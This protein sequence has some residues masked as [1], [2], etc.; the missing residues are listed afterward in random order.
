MA[1]G[2]GAKRQQRSGHSRHRQ[3]R[4]PAVEGERTTVRQPAPDTDPQSRKH[5]DK[6]VEASQDTDEVQDNQISTGAVNH[7]RT[8]R[9]RR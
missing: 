5:H 4:G 6:A 1:H 7:G 2:D 3:H 8:Y 9:F